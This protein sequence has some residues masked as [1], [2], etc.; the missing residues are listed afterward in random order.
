MENGK[1]KWKLET[2]R[3]RAPHPRISNFHFLVSIFPISKTFPHSPPVHPAFN[4]FHPAIGSA[5]SA[6][7]EFAG[8]RVK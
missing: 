1:R 8:L 2:K 7:S 4:F 3:G 6:S 5:F